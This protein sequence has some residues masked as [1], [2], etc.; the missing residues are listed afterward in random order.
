MNYSL[1][2]HKCQQH[3]S[4]GYND[5]GEPQYGVAI[6][7]ACPSNTCSS[8]TQGGC[9]KGYADFAVPLADFVSAYMQDQADNIQW[10]D[11]MDMDNFG[12]CTQY[13]GEGNDNNN[14]AYYY[15]PACTDDGRD[16]KVGLFADSYCY[17]PADVSFEDLSNGWTLPFSDGGLVSYD[18]LS[19]GEDYGN[20]YL[21]LKEMCATL[22][23]DAVLKCE[24]WD[25]QHYYWDAITEVYRF[26]R[27]TTGCKRIGWMDKVD[28]SF[29]EWE[30]ILVLAFLV[31]GSVA[32]GF[33]YQKWWKK[34][35][36]DLEEIPEDED[37]DMTEYH[38]HEDD[39]DDESEKKPQGT[40]A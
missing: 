30:S 21:N 36:E 39:D 23:E 22:Y 12:Q 35:K 40:F 8:N 32:G 34:Q 16:I 15:G 17:N 28:D 13:V 10:D 38:Q 27:D 4:F 7:R 11:R 1:K 14:G 24:E 6:I 26:G 29:S 9:T 2:L 19:C 20:G 33:Y 31:I 25:I 37:E 18:C 5:N 3:E